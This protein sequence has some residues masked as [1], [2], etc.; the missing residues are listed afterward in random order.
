M[1]AAAGPVGADLDGECGA[2]GEL[3]GVP[4]GDV[5]E[6]AVERACDELAV[7]VPGLGPGSS[8]SAP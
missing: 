2:V 5:Q 3:V 8:W 4:A 7:L 6:E 1:G